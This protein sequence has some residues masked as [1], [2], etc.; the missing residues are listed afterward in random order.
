MA[1]WSYS[2]ATA[3]RSQVSSATL[4]WFICLACSR[5]ILNVQW[6]KSAAQQCNA[7][8]TLPT[9]K[10]KLSIRQIETICR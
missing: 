2:S 5:P 3:N 9:G 6:G 10:A 4:V 1:R 7:S 8:F